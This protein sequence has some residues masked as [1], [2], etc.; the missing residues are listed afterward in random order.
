MGD[1]LMNARRRE[2]ISFAD[3]YGVPSLYERR[4]F[5][6]EGG[7]MS[8]GASIVD[9]YLSFPKIPSTRI[10]AI[11]WNQGMI[12]RDGRDPYSAWDVCRRAVQ[13]PAPA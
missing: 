9:Q 10:R 13:V 7:L 2:I 5:P 1:T 3:R 4:D 12:R 6:I 8:Y 11:R